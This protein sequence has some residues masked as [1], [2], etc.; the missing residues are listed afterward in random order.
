[1]WEPNSVTL[2][3]PLCIVVVYERTHR[4]RLF[5]FDYFFSLVMALASGNDHSFSF[6]P[7]DFCDQNLPSRKERA[8]GFPA[9]GK[10]SWPVS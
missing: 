1:M 2:L 5:I 7:L 9:R 3:L 10:E 8:G 6:G 4:K